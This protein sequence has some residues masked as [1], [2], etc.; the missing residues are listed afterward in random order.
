MVERAAL[1]TVTM[2]GG[3][4]HSLIAFGTSHHDFS[5]KRDGGD[6]GKVTRGH[7]HAQMHVAR[8]AREGVASIVSGDEQIAAKIEMHA[9]ML[10]SLR[11][12]LDLV[13]HGVG[14]SGQPDDALRVSGRRERI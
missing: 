5:K 4:T 14:E 10:T 11:Q 3:K 6:R 9:E 8:R 2:G 13:F 7:A 12:R 1:R